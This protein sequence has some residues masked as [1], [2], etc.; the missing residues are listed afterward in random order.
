MAVGLVYYAAVSSRALT[1]QHQQHTMCTVH[2]VA[3]CSS[4]NACTVSSEACWL[5][6]VRRTLYTRHM[7]FSALVLTVFTCSAV[8]EDMFGYY[9]EIVFVAALDT[10]PL[11]PAGT[12]TLCTPRIQRRPVCLIQLRFAAVL[13]GV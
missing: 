4:A 5:L 12:S 2:D 1:R 9:L 11:L 10:Q 3:S 7:C 13:T 6:V 8:P